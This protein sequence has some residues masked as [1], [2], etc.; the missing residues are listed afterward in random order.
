M[1]QSPRNNQQKLLWWL[2]RKVFLD[3]FSLEA[4]HP[5]TF[6]IE[7]SGSSPQNISKGVL[8]FGKL[9]VRQRFEM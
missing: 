6:K 3:A 1:L 5:K 9:T 4:V 7:G 8:L 2:Y